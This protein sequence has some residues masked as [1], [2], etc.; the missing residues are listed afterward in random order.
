M[1]DASLVAI[2]SEFDGRAADY[3]D[4]IFHRDLAEAV[5]EFADLTGVRTVLDVA[6]GTGLALRA[7]EDRAPGLDLTGV[8]ISPGMLAVARAALPR[9]RW[10][11][12]EA[13][14]LPLPDQAVDLITCVTALHLIPDTARAT[15]EWRRVLRPGATVVTATF[16]RGGRHLAPPK[17]RPFAVDHDSFDT[18]GTLRATFA[19]FGFAVA[20]HHEW[21]GDEMGMLIA[22]L[23]AEG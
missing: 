13:A 23:R 19:P 8:D 5:A 18:A 1:T 17:Q 4:G 22:E 15:A 14:A 9:A 10:I 20:R 3:D 7:L 2:R 21:R 6:T 11:E 16:L 12:A